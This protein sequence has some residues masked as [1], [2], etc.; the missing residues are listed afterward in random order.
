MQL[1]REKLVSDIGRQIQEGKYSNLLARS[2]KKM[3]ESGEISAE[4]TELM[5][6]ER[7]PLRQEAWFSPFLAK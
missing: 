7:N 4:R 2:L 3:I 1:S 6:A 5:A